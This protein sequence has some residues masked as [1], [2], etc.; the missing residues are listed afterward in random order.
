MRALEAEG[1]SV[2]IYD[3]GHHAQARD[4]D[5]VGDFATGQ[6]L[7]EALTGV[8]V[9]FHLISTTIPST[10]D[11]DP[12][13]DV[14]SNLVGT[15]R[16]LEVMETAGVHRIVFLSSGGTVYGNPRVLPVPETAPLEPI[17]SYGVVKA[18]IENYLRIG[19]KLHGV[20]ATALRLANPYGPGETRIGVHGVIATFFARVAA[21]EEIVIWGD[22]S[23]VR[24]YIHVD[25]AIGAMLT[26]A[27]LDGFNLY[28]VGSGE[29]HSLTEILDIVQRISGKKAKVS[30]RPA[31]A[32]DVQEIYLDIA[33][34][35][36][37]TDWTPRIALEQ[38]CALLWAAMKH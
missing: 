18:G 26:A 37:E 32:F 13:F 27:T 1:V 36:G 12:T 19:A 29:G 15:L 22:G 38:G 10:S 30:F 33:R 8:D 35:T 34:I 17:C 31:R 16:L 24:D 5:I 11:A 28:N 20:H 4:Q 9:V 2:R 25:D 7:L 21:E 3:R 23:V 6:R 14:T